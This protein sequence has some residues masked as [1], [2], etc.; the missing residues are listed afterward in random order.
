MQ[1]TGSLYD[2][3][4]SKMKKLLFVFFLSFFWPTYVNAHASVLSPEDVLSYKTIFQLQHTGKIKEAQKKEA[5]IKNPLLKGYLLYDRYFSVYYKTQ[6]EEI[7][8]WMKEY[9]DHPIAS[10]IY[11]LG[12]QKKIK[13]LPRPKGIFG[14]NTKACESVSRIEPL[15][16][17][18]ALNF[19]Y[20]NREKKRKAYK[21]KNQFIRYLS[22][23]KTLN[24]KRVLEE[25]ETK[26]LFKSSDLY[27]AKIALGYSYFLDNEDKLAMEQVENVLNNTYY[28]P[29]FT[30]WLAGLLK[31]REG[32][33]LESADFF[34]KS[35]DNASSDALIGRS[36][37]WAARAYMRA[38][39]YHKV[40]DLLEKAASYPRYFYGI[41]ALR[42]LGNNLE[43]VWDLPALPEEEVSAE[44]SHPALE[45]FYALKQIGQ[46]RWAIDELLKLYLEADDEAKGI[47]WLISE[48]NGFQEILKSMIGSLNGGQTRYPFPDWTPQNDWLLDKALI[49]A[50]VRQESCFNKRAQSK[51]GATGLMQIM[52]KTAKELAT[53]LQCDWNERKLKEPEYNLAL[54][55]SYL[56]KI[57][58][59]DAVQN[60]LIKTA[61]A[62]NAGPGNLTKWEKK[63]NYNEDP[64][65]FLE[66]LPSKETRS[67]IER[68]L[69]NYWV[70][71][72]L[73]NEPLDSL[74]DTVAGHWPIYQTCQ[75]TN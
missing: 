57:M 1:K 49:Y 20:L 68:I 17:V 28:P 52:P 31:W 41:L 16:L 6:K 70:Y 26:N 46:E 23:G 72:D 75:K 71:R 48:E 42:S 69:V 73:M 18:N 25:K 67:F 30:Y 55:Q 24:A 51:A 32:N 8:N 19:S 66:T 5:Q 35:S 61:V 12:E 47:L 43:H 27:T 11:A 2:S 64:L 38:G 14:G 53:E 36:A 15:D 59:H 29:V 3:A 33:F 45:R 50:F 65:M 13:D 54:G 63:M 74:D 37:F 56:Q 22:Q 60:N 40:G 58:S 34:E 4:K 10:E 62:Y 9:S 44:F 21:K 39:E 7:Q